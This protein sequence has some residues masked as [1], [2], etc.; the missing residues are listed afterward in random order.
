MVLPLPASYEGKERANQLPM[1]TE[2]K[3]PCIF[4]V[5]G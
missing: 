2:K 3:K 5:L 4:R 1:E